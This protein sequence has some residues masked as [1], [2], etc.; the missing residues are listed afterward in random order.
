MTDLL[1][2]YQQMLKQEKLLAK[3]PREEHPGG[4]FAGSALCAPCHR[5]A[6]D[7][8]RRSRHPGAYQ[9][10]VKKSRDSDP[11]CAV[12]HTVGLKYTSGFV[13]AEA[14]PG[15]GHVGCESCH[16][17]GKAHN[18]DPGGVKIP[19]GDEATCRKCH[20]TDNDPEFEFK[21]YWPKIRHG[22]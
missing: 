15:L 3:V 18:D 10:L 9:T 16:G 14:T 11:E 22:K 6:A 19:K 1:S 5:A 17:P 8:W 13:S 12:C 7:V 21:T 4:E 2:L 20:D